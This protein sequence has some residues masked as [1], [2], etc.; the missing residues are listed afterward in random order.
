[1][2]FMKDC[3]LIEKI[4]KNSGCYVSFLNNLLCDVLNIKR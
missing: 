2:I 1:M 3:R 4:I